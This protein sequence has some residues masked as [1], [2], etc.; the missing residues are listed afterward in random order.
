M[1]NGRDRPDSEESAADQA[2][3][4]GLVLAKVGDVGVA[5]FPGQNPRDVLLVA[6]VIE[7]CLDI[8]A[9]PSRHVARH[10]LRAL[11]EAGSGRS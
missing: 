4:G 8:G 6:D 3:G 10:I 11:A 7:R 5:V 9:Y 1:S 2:G